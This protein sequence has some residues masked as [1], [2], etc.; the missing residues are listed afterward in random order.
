MAPLVVPQAVLVRLIWTLAGSAYAINV[1]GARK[2]GAAAIDQAFAN[3]LGA[4]I[5]G[6]A[7]TT[8]LL[9]SL[10]NQV[11]L[12][13]IGVRDISGPNL[14]EFRD[15]AAA[16]PGSAATALLPLQ[17]AYCV[18]LRTAKA[19]K[20]YRGRTYIPGWTVTNVTTGGQTTAGVP[21]TSAAFLTGIKTVMTANGLTLAIVSR[22]LLT[23]EP[24]T[25]EQGRDTIW[26]TIRKRATPGV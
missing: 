21:T 10:S 11:A 19:G 12:A 2:S 4:A 22:T 26:D 25:L 6:H 1:L 13:N 15:S 18:T 14:P 9:T 16:V 5:K 7:N 8:A 24:V 3:T 23:T 17:I 20:N